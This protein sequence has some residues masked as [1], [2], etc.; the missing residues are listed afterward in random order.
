LADSI[1][2]VFKLPVL[3]TIAINYAAEVAASNPVETP[4]ADACLTREARVTELSLP[5]PGGIWNMEYGKEG[6]MER[7]INIVALMTRW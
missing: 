1:P 2:T 3:D 4:I 7:N 6:N 5:C